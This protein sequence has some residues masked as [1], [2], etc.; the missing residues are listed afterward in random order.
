M[1]RPRCRSEIAQPL[2]AFKNGRQHL[3]LE[4]AGNLAARPDRGGQA[5]A[6]RCS[7]WM[8]AEG[9][10]FMPIWNRPAV[11]PMATAPFQAHS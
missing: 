6:V 11:M 9:F 3:A 4:R 2:A 8:R 10:T 5:A 7:A 1:P